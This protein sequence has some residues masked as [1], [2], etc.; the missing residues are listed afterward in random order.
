MYN[1]HIIGIVD[2]CDILRTNTADLCE[3]IAID[4]QRVLV[5]LNNDKLIPTATHNDIGSIGGVSDYNKA[6]ILVSRLQSLLQGKNDH[7]SYL[8][9]ICD[10]LLKIETTQAIAK[11]MKEELVYESD[12]F[13]K[14]MHQY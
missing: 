3:A 5:R 10:S 9:Q 14:G 4:V 2:P 7:K 1:I 11:K 6:S 13:K 8:L 12:H